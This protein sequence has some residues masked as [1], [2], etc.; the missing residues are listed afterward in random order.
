MG[1]VVPLAD[2]RADTSF[3]ARAKKVADAVDHY[4]DF[5]LGDIAE[6]AAEP[7]VL[8]T[9]PLPKVT[10]EKEHAPISPKAEGQAPDL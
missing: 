6:G 4:D 7:P 10:G 5:D 2:K 3:E 8:T 9:P 1:K